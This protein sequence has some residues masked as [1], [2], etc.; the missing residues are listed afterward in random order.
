MKYIE[1]LINF[2]N[3]ACTTK[4]VHT[5]S[6]VPEFDRLDAVHFSKVNSKPSFL[7][8]AFIT[9]MRAIYDILGEIFVHCILCFKSS[10][11]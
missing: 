10:K 7:N 11:L 8:V 5:V 1:K 2:F 9:C 6:P 4:T 3:I